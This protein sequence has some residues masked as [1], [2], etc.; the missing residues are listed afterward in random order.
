MMLQPCH[1]SCATLMVKAAKIQN[2]NQKFGEVFQRMTLLPEGGD[3]FHLCKPR[4]KTRA[5][6]TMAGL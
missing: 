5:I 2:E 3:F 1:L 6:A 4:G